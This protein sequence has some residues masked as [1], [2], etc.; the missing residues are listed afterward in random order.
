VL[1]KRL[2]V[3]WTTMA[4]SSNDE[5]GVPLDHYRQHNAGVLMIC[6]RCAFTRSVDLEP[7]IERLVARGLD[8]PSIGVREAA[9]YVRIN[10][11]RCGVWSWETR[12]DFP[13]RPGQDGLPLDQPRRRVT[14]AH[15]L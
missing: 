9:R 5:R 7:L 6:R 4:R 2:L 10:C 1:F 14:E 3:G 8:G 11:P 12:P 13:S 15:R